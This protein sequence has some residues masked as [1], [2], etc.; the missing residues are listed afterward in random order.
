MSIG[1][2]GGG[3]ALILRRLFRGWLLHGTL[4]TTL[5]RFFPLFGIERERGLFEGVVVGIGILFVGI[6]ANGGLVLAFAGFFFL[7]ACFASAYFGYLDGV[8][9]NHL[10]QYLD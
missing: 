10:P 4:I 3:I 6:G 7:G 8:Q 2:N 1:N 5:V 9:S